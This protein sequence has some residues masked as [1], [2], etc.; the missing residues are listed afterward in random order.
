MNKNKFYMTNKEIFFDCLKNIIK[1]KSVHPR[2]GAG[3]IGMSIIYISFI[4]EIVTGFQLISKYIS[5]VT[6][7]AVIFGIMF[8]IKFKSKYNPENN[9][10]MKVG[11]FLMFFTIA[12]I[13]LGNTYYKYI[14]FRVIN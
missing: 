5:Y 7:I 4:L 9:D 8:F 13:Y 2:L 3:T 6:I 1:V 14:V 10:N 12:I 11:V